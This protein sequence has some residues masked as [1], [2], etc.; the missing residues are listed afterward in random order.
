MNSNIK[1]INIVPY[2]IDNDIA[3]YVTIYYDKS[4]VR[5]NDEENRFIDIIKDTGYYP[6]YIENIKDNNIVYQFIYCIP[7]YNITNFPIRTPLNIYAVLP[8]NIS[9]INND[10]NYFYMFYP[11]KNN[12]K[13]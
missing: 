1:D 12:I 6:F 13:F 2:L 9:D 8:N 7:Y 3:K 5:C 4:Y 11:S 10:I